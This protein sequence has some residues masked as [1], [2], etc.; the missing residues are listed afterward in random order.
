MDIRPVGPATMTVAGVAGAAGRNQVPLRIAYMVGSTVMFAGDNAVVNGQLANLSAGQVA[1]GRTLFAFLTTA[2]IV[3]PRAGWGLLR[4]R[5]Y[6]EHL[7]RELWQ[8][9]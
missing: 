5:R 6:R 8:F 9:G 3:L 4:T 7:Q 2:A 1:F